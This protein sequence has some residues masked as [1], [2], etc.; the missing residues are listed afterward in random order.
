MPQGKSIAI[1]N[2]PISQTKAL[3]WALQHLLIENN[4]RT[5]FIDGKKPRWVE[6]RFK[7]VL[8]DKGIT[9]KKLRTVRHDSSP[10][11]RLADALAGLSRSYY[12]N[13]DGRAKPLWNKIQKQITTQLVGGQTD[14]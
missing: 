6:R 11:I 4:F 8:R 14:W 12:D 9:V 13:P 2:N 1:F 10:C 7:K 5:I 3:E